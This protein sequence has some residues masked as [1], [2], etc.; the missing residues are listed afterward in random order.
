MRCR[1][2]KSGMGESEE[3]EIDAAKEARDWGDT[4][5][6]ASLCKGDVGGGFVD[7]K[8]RTSA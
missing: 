6:T 4:D 3:V 8:D 2:V 1:M 5:N 7:R